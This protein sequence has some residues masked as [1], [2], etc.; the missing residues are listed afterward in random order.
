LNEF[1]NALLIVSPTLGSDTFEHH[2]DLG[3]NHREF[4]FDGFEH[5]LNLAH[6]AAIVFRQ[7]LIELV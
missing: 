3:L 7:P 2:I 6:E 4:P 1:R 5:G